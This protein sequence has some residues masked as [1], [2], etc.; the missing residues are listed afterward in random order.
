MRLFNECEVRLFLSNLATVNKS[1]SRGPSA[2]R[3]KQ[4]K[5][6]EVSTHSVTLES[7]LMQF[8]AKVKAKEGNIKEIKAD[9]FVLI[10]K[11]WRCLL[12]ILPGG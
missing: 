2:H 8:E 9:D 4:A 11:A 10:Y 7:K 5:S 3:T 1:A 6:Q 12:T